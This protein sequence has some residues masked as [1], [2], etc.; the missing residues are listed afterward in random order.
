MPTA[1]FDIFDQDGSGGIDQAEFQAV[2][3]TFAHHMG[4]Q[5]RE[6]RAPGEEGR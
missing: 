5:V 4:Y 6:P 1:L 2:Q 3:A